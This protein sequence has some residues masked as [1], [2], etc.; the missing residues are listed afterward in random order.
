[1]AD[2]VFDLGGTTVKQALVNSSGELSFKKVQSTPRNYLDLLDYLE[3]ASHNHQAARAIGLSVPGIYN[4]VKKILTGSSAI[5]Y[6]IGKSLVVDLQKPVFIENDG[7][8]AL[9]GELWLGSAK[10]IQNVA[11]YVI[12]SAVG[13]AIAIQGNILHGANLNAGKLWL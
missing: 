8:C 1:M 10:G 2:L 7:N 4:Q 5:S 3:K 9:L 12:G 13:G 6:I 11:M